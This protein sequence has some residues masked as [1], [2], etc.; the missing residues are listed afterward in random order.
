MALFSKRIQAII[1]T[2]LFICTAGLLSCVTKEEIKPVPQ[3]KEIHDQTL[4]EGFELVNG[5]QTPLGSGMFLFAKKSGPVILGRALFFA[6]DAEKAEAIANTPPTTKWEG[7]CTA[8]GVTYSVGRLDQVVEVTKE[9][10]RADV[11]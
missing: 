9:G 3:C 11:D 1:T 6:V 8:N 7:Q 4:Q 5:G 2:I 10:G